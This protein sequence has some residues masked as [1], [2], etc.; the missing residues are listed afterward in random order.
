MIDRVHIAYTIMAGSL[1]TIG[2]SGSNIVSEMS[3]SSMPW[4][5]LLFEGG[6][7]GIAILVMI[8]AVKY[9]RQKDKKVDELN[10]KL[11]AEKDKRIE[12]LRNQMMNRK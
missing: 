8:Y 3:D 11:I 4:S 12:D 2:A 10:N 5:S 7:S 9:L 1:V 6:V